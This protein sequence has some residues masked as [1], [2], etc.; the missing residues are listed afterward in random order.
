MS[1][2]IEQV[3]ESENEYRDRRSLETELQEIV[4]AKTE[5]SPTRGFWAKRR[6][7]S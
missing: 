5:P 1:E 6:I 3:K 4:R 2:T 7:K